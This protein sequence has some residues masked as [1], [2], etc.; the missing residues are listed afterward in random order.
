M[1]SGDVSDVSNAQVRNQKH[2]LVVDGKVKNLYRI[3]IETFP[4][5]QQI[6]ENM[7]SINTLMAVSWRIFR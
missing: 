6:K 4:T 2:N 5:A 3:H 1:L 7:V